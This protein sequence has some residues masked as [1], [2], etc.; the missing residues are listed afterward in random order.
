MLPFN[1]SL[2]SHLRR[3]NNLKD[4]MRLRVIMTRISFNLASQEVVNLE[5]LKT[6]TLKV[7]KT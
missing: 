1:F 7:R 4:E 2:H 3:V 5:P 6:N